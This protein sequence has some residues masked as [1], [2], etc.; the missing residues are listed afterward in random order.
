MGSQESF[1]KAMAMV[2]A[3]EI[4]DGDEIPKSDQRK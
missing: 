3:G 1:L 2:P 4:V